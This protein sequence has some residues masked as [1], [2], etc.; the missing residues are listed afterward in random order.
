VDMGRYN[1]LFQKI[2]AQQARLVV[3]DGLGN[4]TAINWLDNI[5]YFARRKIDRRW[6]RFIGRLRNY[7]AETMRAY[8]DTPKILDSAYRKTG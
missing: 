3:I 4:H 6:Q 8:G 1:I 7:S 5:A 2:S